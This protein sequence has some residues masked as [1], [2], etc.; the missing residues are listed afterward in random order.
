MEIIIDGLN[1]NY[2]EKGEGDPVL[3]LHGWGS[4]NVPFN[5][6]INSFLVCYFPSNVIHIMSSSH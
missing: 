6:I 3:M 1:I 2:V 4:S 5:N